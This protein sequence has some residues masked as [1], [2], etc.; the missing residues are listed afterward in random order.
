MLKILNF[1][2]KWGV[3]ISTILVLIIFLKTC[4]TNTKV[5]S[6]K[7][8]VEVLN[9]KVDTLGVNLTKEIKIEGL[10][11]EKR[12]IQSTDRKILDVNRQTEIDK[13]LSKLEK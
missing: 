8:Q 3:R 12:M 6:V 2:D 1:I 5:E 9:H 10:K 7:K 4:N 11:S 13:E